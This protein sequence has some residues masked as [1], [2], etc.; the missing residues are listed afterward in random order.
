MSAH[1]PQMDVQRKEG[2]NS[3]LNYGQG[4]VATLNNGHGSNVTLNKSQGSQP[5]INKSHGTLNRSQVTLDNVPNDGAHSGLSKPGSKMTAENASLS[6][7]SADNASHHSRNTMDNI[8]HHSRK[9]AD[10][11][12]HSRISADNLSIPMV[13]P[14]KMESPKP[15]P[16]IRSKVSEV[17]PISPDIN[18]EAIGASMISLRTDEVEVSKC[19]VC[20]K[21]LT[22][23][24]CLP[25]LHTFCESCIGRHVATSLSQGKAVQIRCPVCATPVSSA[26]AI[27]DP[28]EFAKSLPTNHF[29]SSLMAERMLK[30]K[31][32]KP[33]LRTQK[34]STAVTWCSYCAET[35]CKEHDNYH[36]GLT[37][38]D[39]H[40][41]ATIEEAQ[42]DKMMLYAPGLCPNH[43]NEKLV[44]FCHDHR[45][46]CC[47]VCKKTV[48]KN[49]DDVVTTEEA[50]KS[51]KDT[52]ETHI[53]S[54]MLKSINAQT[55]EIVQG[56]KENIKNLEA[57]KSKEEDAIRGFREEI[58]RHLDTLEQNLREEL[59]E[60]HRQKIS[61]LQA[62]MD[63]FETKRMTVAYYKDLLHALMGS[64]SGI[65]VINELGKVGQQCAIL[66]EKVQHRASKVKRVNYELKQNDLTSNL[67]S[68][69][70]VDF[71]STP[72]IPNVVSEDW[73]KLRSKKSVNKSKPRESTHDFMVIKYSH[74]KITGGCS[75][76][77]KLVL[78]DN[79]GRE[80]RGYTE[81]GHRDESFTISFKKNPWDLTPLPERDGSDMI[82]VTLHN[83][84]QIQV[85]EYGQIPLPDKHVY[86][87]RTNCFGIA[88]LEGF[89]VVACVQGLEVAE[90]V[91]DHR[92]VYRNFLR[93]PGD[94]IYYVCSGD[95]NR[96][97]YSDAVEK[98]SLYCITLDGTEIFQYS[99]VT[100]RSPRGIST[101][102]TGNVFVCGY[103]S[104]N[105]HQ[106]NAEGALMHI[107][108]PKSKTFYKP[109]VLIE[110]SERMYSVF[111]KHKVIVFT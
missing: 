35:L 41:T 80:I 5:N 84:C 1:L 40:K 87:T 86:H 75:Y 4:S 78:V 94:K 33:C 10:N 16:S 61:E 30:Q 37:S 25:C 101:D 74:S 58:D 28:L 89:I 108:A 52:K 104:N 63:S 3:T 98:G 44:Y 17:R 7:V 14:T 12:S 76:K 68:L 109:L 65:Q 43:M 38:S 64:T 71:R 45:E 69:G 102:S 42:K 15:T 23:P 91:D 100:L 9:T 8:S 32:C 34:K 6:K 51:L 73:N 70:S 26:R 22:S 82:A 90:L 79:T 66:E 21:E 2:S 106:L 103:Y 54:Q 18:M 67:D 27:T 53:L 93:V 29:I 55:D 81:M 107:I 105:I 46:T 95:K 50:A 88:Y 20:A 13:T 96:I 110:H 60:K 56:R 24:K 111:G 62:E 39:I 99:H 48:H 47:E 36:R 72:I 85:I 77:S 19:P 92:L 97:Y 57:E 59:R 49:C 31:L 83:D 11:V